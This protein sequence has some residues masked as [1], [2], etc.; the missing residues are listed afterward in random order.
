MIH[1]KINDTINTESENDKPAI[2]IDA[3]SWVKYGLS[4]QDKISGIIPSIVANYPEEF[5]YEAYRSNGP[6]IGENAIKESCI[7]PSLNFRFPIECGIPIIFEDTELIINHIFE[8]ELRIESDTQSV[9]MMQKSLLPKTFSVQ[10]GESLFEKF[11]VEQT[12]F[13]NSELATLSY[14]GRTTGLIVDMGASQTMIVP[15]VEGAPQFHAIQR[16]ELGGRDITEKLQILLEDSYQDSIKF[17]SAMELD[18]LRTLKEKSCVVSETWE[19]VQTL[20]DIY[21]Q[22]EKCYE[23]PDGQE[24]K[25]GFER[26]KATEILFNNESFGKVSDDNLPSKI[27]ASINTC[28][29]SVRRELY[30]NIILVGGNSL[31]QGLKT[32][33]KHEMLNIVPSTVQVNIITYENRGYLPWVSGSLLSSYAT[34]NNFITRQQY[35]DMGSNVFLRKY[36]S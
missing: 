15:V 8:S 10:Y 18:I 20:Q 26:V 7:S 6:F 33:L 1:E 25:I 17:R 24:I 11:N 9:V 3:G 19:D 22:N 12:S 35:E 34:F 28:D 23:L 29:L 36:Q 14:T 30:K 31:L 21:T 4:G 13:I 32:R 16:L 5:E 27:K 2:V